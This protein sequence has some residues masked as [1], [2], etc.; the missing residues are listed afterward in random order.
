MRLLKQKILIIAILPLLFI[1]CVLLYT[2]D[3]YLLKNSHKFHFEQGAECTTCHVDI[4]KSESATDDNLPDKAVCES[5]HDVSDNQKCTTCHTRVDKAKKL[6]QRNTDL[7]FSHKLHVGDNEIECKQ[8]HP[9]A[10]ES[11]KSTDNLIPVM[12]ACDSCHDTQAADS[13]CQMCHTNLKSLTLKPNNHRN[14]SSFV[15]NHEQLVMKKTINY[16][17]NCHTEES[18]LSCHEGRIDRNVHN[19]NFRFYHGIEARNKPSSCD[20][21]HRKQFCKECH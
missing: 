20:V 10:Y 9:K 7:I 17:Y 2:T 3:R 5:C 12:K 18:C 4:A 1:G 6:E 21:C 11:L 8:C 19:R 13:N 16:C 15:T 14:R